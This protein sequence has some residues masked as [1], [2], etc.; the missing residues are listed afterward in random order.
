MPQGEAGELVAIA[1]GTELA[2]WSYLFTAAFLP[3]AYDFTCYYLAGTA[4]AIRTLGV[5]L[6]AARTP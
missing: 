6:A 2:V 1:L 4:A 3:V 5:R